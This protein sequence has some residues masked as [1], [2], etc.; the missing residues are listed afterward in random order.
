MGSSVEHES[1]GT[2]AERYGD[3]SIPSYVRWQIVKRFPKQEPADRSAGVSSKIVRRENRYN[4]LVEK[5]KVP[6]SKEALA[7]FSEAA[8]KIDPSHHAAF[9]AETRVSEIPP[10]VYG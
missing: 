2:K 8:A 9:L 1:K 7:S 10:F 5:S 3:P 4:V 6:A